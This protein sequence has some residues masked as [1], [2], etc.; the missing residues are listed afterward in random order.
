[1]SIRFFSGKAHQ[2]P[3]GAM[4]LNVNQLNLVSG[5]WTVVELDTIMPEYT[6]GIENTTT[7]RI[8]PGVPGLYNLQ[9]QVVFADLLAGKRYNAGIRLNGDDFRANST[10]HASL[11]EQVAA[12]TFVTLYLSATDYIELMAQNRSGVNTVDVERSIYNTF[13]FVQRVR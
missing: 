12:N 2:K 5:T 3:S 4:Y 1:M 10:Q 7:H 13:L 11:A 8:T 6:D 9:G